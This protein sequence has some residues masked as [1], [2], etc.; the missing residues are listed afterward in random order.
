MS[1]VHV[2]DAGVVFIITVSDESGPVNLTTAQSVNLVFQKP[3]KSILTVD[4]TVFNANA[5]IVHYVSTVNDF[6]QSGRWR[7]QAKV[8]F[9]S[10]N[11]KHSDV[12]VMTIAK[13]IPL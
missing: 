3:D 1:V 13:N 10:D 4:C 5:G 9:A 2:N 12:G 7:V 11:V 6:D 8:T